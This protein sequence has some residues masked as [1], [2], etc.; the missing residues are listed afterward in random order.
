MNMTLPENFY[1]IQAAGPANGA[2][3]Q[4]TSTPVSLK[5]IH[6]LWAVIELD[7]AGTS[8]AVACVP[9]TDALVAFGSPAVLTTAVPKWVNADVATSAVGFTHPA[10]AVN[11]TTT[12]DALRKCVIFEIDPTAHFGTSEDCFRIS[13]TAVAAGDYYSIFYI[14]EPRYPA[15]IGSQPS[16]LVD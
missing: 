3:A 15:A 6:R 8:A 12:A 5:Y 10:N 11:H 16:V 9:Q 13:L 7:T 1:V 14:I 2:G 4:V